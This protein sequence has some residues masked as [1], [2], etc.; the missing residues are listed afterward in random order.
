MID[1]EEGALRSLEKHALAGAYLLVE[2]K[3]GIRDVGLQLFPKSLITTMDIIEVERFLFEDRFQVNIFFLDIVLEL[4]AKGVFFQEIDEANAD[5]RYLVFVSRPDAASGGADLAFTAKSLASQIDGFVVRHDQ[6]RLFADAQKGV[7]RRW[8]CF[9]RALISSIRIS[10]SIT[11]P[12]P[13][14]QSLFACSAPE[15]TR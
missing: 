11:T 3:A 1:I 10:G 9:F 6:V 5:P 8:P 7:V 12:L 15:G 4:L 2:Q 14:T 13:M